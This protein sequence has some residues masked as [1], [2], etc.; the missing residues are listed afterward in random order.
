M[1]VTYH[2]ESSLPT[3]PPAATPGAFDR[4]K[5]DA[6]AALDTMFQAT[7]AAI[8]ASEAEQQVILL[9]DT[10]SELKR[11]KIRV[12]VQRLA[13]PEEICDELPF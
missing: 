11:L 12:S 6:I 13:G 3:P 5:A 7:V 1:A 2:I 4:A 8:M 9:T 10:L